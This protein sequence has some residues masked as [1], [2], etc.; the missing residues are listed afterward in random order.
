[1]KLTEAGWSFDSRDLMRSGCDHCIR[2][3]V[4]RE[5]GIAG[6]GDL[7]ASY[8]RAP[9][10]LPIQY[11][12]RYEGAL[13]AELRQNLGDLVQRPSQARHEDTV[14]LMRQG[15][16]VIYQGALRGGTA[17]ITFSGRPD[18][19]LRGDYQFRFGESGLT[20][21]KVSGDSSSYSAWDAKLS[22]NPKPEYQNQVA[23][24][25]DVLAE[26]GLLSDAASGLLLGNRTL[27]AF[28]AAALLANLEI[29][30]SRLLNRIVELTGPSAPTSIADLGELVCDRSSGCELCEYPDL[31]Q[32]QRQQLDHLQLVANIT[33][34]QIAKLLAAGV[35]T[36]SQLAALTPQH[37]GYD[38][39]LVR[40]ASA[41]LRSSDGTPYAQVTNPELLAKLPAPSVHDIFFDIEGFTFAPPGGIEYLLGWVTV[42]GPRPKFFGLWSDDRRTERRNFRRFVKFLVRRH[43]AHPNFKVYHYARYEKTAL[44]R[45]AKRHAMLSEEVDQLIENGVFV[46]LY[47]VVLGAVCV[48]QPRYSIKN[49][50]LYYSF[51]RSSP[52]KEAMGSMEYY[53]AYLAAARVNRTQA[54]T[55]K[56][57]V[58]DYNRDDCVS[59]LALRDWLLELG[60]RQPKP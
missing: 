45:L 44:K 5:L 55:L 10:G 50:E 6:L 16:P 12:N 9:T 2:L 31:C 15:V 7:L 20:A 32:A 25:C 17:A 8:Y 21:V 59:T 35:H 46:D 38:E 24:Y 54:K 3:A 18:F 41:Q 53:D 26:L 13:E 33:A 1:M 47:E 14:T 4:G 43:R 58:L 42:D 51:E 40:Q 34:S 27:G 57:Q 52:V 49:L 11:G 39:K 19:L 23:L 36:M 60:E 37:P 48:G 29:P 56:R 30:R 22:S 28:D